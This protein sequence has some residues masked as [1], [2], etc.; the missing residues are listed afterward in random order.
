MHLFSR[1]RLKA[2]IAII[3]IL[4]SLVSDGLSAQ[5][6]RR[7]G[8]RGS[9]EIVQPDQAA[10]D[11]PTNEDL[12]A[13][14]PENEQMNS[15]TAQP[16]LWFYIPFAAKSPLSGKLTLRKAGPS[17][18]ILK[19]DSLLSKDYSSPQLKPSRYEML[20]YFQ[21]LLY[22]DVIELEA[23]ALP[24]TLGI[25][26]VQVPQALKKDTPYQWYFAVSCKTA[27]S[28][29][30]LQ[31]DGWVRWVE[32]PTSFLSQV[33]QA[34]SVEQMVRLYAD[35]AYW[36]DALTLLATYRDRDSQAQT[37]WTKALAAEKMA[38]FAAEPI[39]SCCSPRPIETK[40]PTFT[41]TVATPLKVPLN[42]LKKPNL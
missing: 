19:L 9:C 22:P 17:K 26:S 24:Q 31:V 39:L 34:K 42:K 20:A 2:L 40:W 11:A 23:I 10:A 15:A 37:I 14:M 32:P 36:P 30:S 35:A 33:Q 21:Q 38:E 3:V 18:P 5:A 4:T 13:L 1:K 28:T 16:Q 41:E 12:V 7:A 25:V 27:G 6:R 29:R 8:T